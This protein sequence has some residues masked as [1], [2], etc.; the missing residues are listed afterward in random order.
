M[1][2]LS[3][4]INSKIKENYIYK[5]YIELKEKI[6]NDEALM[7]I[8]SELD[9]LKNEIC[10]SKESSLVDEYYKLEKEYQN[11]HL[12][13]EYLVYKEELNVLLKDIANILSVN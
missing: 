4:I 13:K 9:C 10:K 12:V 11:H 2:E 3:L 8:K 5:K 6:E 7:N 1:E